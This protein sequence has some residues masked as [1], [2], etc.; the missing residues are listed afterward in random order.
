MDFCVAGFGANNSKVCLLPD[1]KLDSFFCHS[2]A[3]LSDPGRRARC[4][5]IQLDIFDFPHYTRPPTHLIPI[6]QRG[7]HTHLKIL[8]TMPKTRSHQESFKN[9]C[10]GGN[11]L[12]HYTDSFGGS[13]RRKPATFFKTS[14]SM[15]R[16]ICTTSQ[17]SRMSRNALKTG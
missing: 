15:Y 7:G 1:P 10:V 6:S 2:L 14:L 12:P 8:Q 3:Y 17:C 9:S 4:C 13:A 16:I 5:N 11:F